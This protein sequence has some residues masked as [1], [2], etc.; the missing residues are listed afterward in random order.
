MEQMNSITNLDINRE[1]IWYA[2][3]PQGISAAAWSVVCVS[4]VAALDSA[5]HLAYKATLPGQ[6]S[7]TDIQSK[8]DLKQIITKHVITFFWVLRV[9]ATKSARSS[10]KT[11]SP[12]TH[13]RLGQRISPHT[14]LSRHLITLS[15]KWLH[16]LDICFITCW[17]GATNNNDNNPLR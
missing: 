14:S 8:A 3:P 15:C 1:N 6:S 12:S 7:N 13:H 10:Q 9:R 2:R 5:R 11:L 16:L 4:A 17:T